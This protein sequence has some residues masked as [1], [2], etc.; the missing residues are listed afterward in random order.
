MG[1]VTQLR[2]DGKGHD[3]LEIGETYTYKELVSRT[4]LTY[5]CL[6][7]RVANLKNGTGTGNRGIISITDK[8]LVP[9]NTK[10]IP[11]T[12]RNQTNRSPESNLETETMQTSQK[13]LRRKW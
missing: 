5:R 4:G 12:W 13:W 8:E 2:Y 1:N 10:K 9:L 11:L 6:V 7:G 3:N